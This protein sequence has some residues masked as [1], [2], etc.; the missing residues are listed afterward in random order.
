[1]AKLGGSGEGHLC[2]WPAALV[3]HGNLWETENLEPQSKHWETGS[4]LCQDPQELHFMHTG[5]FVEHYHKW[6]WGLGRQPPERA[7][8]RWLNQ[9]SWEFPAGREEERAVVHLFFL[10]MDFMAREWFMHSN[11]KARLCA[12]V[13]G[14][15]L[16]SEANPDLKLTSFASSL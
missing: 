5:K 2:P 6:S 14:H 4:T 8:T 3:S 10:L 9:K 15:E 11:S 16:W 7:E 13:K 12:V 1:M